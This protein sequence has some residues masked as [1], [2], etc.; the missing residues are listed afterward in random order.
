MNEENHLSGRNSTYDTHV[1][2]SFENLDDHSS[3]SIQAHFEKANDNS[4]LSGSQ[5]MMLWSR[6]VEDPLWQM[7]IKLVRDIHVRIGCYANY[8][9][10]ASWIDE[11]NDDTIN[12]SNWTEWSGIWAEIIRVISK[13]NERAAWVQFEITSMI[14]DQNCTTRGSITTLLHPFWNHPNT[15]LGKFKYFI[16]AVLS[17]SEMKFIHFWGGKSKSFGNKS[18]K[19]WH[20]ILFVFH[21]L[22]MWLVTLNK[23]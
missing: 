12:N 7:V 14:S 23:P 16:D 22:A 4:V 19:I 15:G 3:F 1:D 20:M 6:R 21:F 8:L 13:S 11:P 9:R 17:W 10:Y 2:I 18:C 5:K